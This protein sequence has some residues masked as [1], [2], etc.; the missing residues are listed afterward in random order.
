MINMKR[1]IVALTVLMTICTIFVQAQSIKHPWWVADRGG[2][3]STAGAITLRSSIGQSTIQRM[4]YIDTGSVLESGFTPG[5]RFLSGTAMTVGYQAES[6]WNMLSLPLRVSNNHVTVL[7]PSATSHAFTFAGSYAARD[8]LDCG[9]GYWLKFPE[10][11]PISYYGTTFSRD[12]LDV[13]DGWNMIGCTSYSIIVSEIMAIAPTTFLPSIFSYSS[14]SGYNTEDTLRPGYGYWI[15][16]HNTG[17]IVL[18]AGSVLNQPRVVSVSV[19][20][21]KQEE[22]TETPTQQFSQL[23]FADNKGRERTLLFL[24]GISNIDLAKYELP[25]ASPSGL[26]VRYSS[27]R[28]LEV[29]DRNTSKDAIIRITDAAYPM[30]ISWTGNNGARIIIDK[31]EIELRSDGETILQNPQQSQDDVSASVIK[32]R[33][34]PSQAHEQIPTQFA[35]MQNYPNPFNPS[36]T[37]HYELPVESRVF[38]RLYNL[39]GEEVAML[40][41]EVRKAGYESVEWNTAGIAS[42]V[43]FYRLEATSVDNPS[44]SFV[45]V[46]K[47]MLMK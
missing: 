28:K 11:T 19:P 33:L 23:T 9:G 1:N 45:E 29:A 10:S 26:D 44:M 8:T 24:T 15:K 13:M 16:V 22:A 46:K 37:I 2:G 12:T 36:T 7:Y 17:K 5:I 32:L 21:Q 14:G 42:G 34:S 41:N 4:V 18:P 25:P 30:K 31:K 47:M 35:L 40:V 6:G 39:L 27:N 38:I 43:Y 3:K 20:Q